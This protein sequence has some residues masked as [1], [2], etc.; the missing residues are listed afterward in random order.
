MLK[1]T[2]TKNKVKK[3]GKGFEKYLWLNKFETEASLLVHSKPF[4]GLLVSLQLQF[5][6]LILGNSLQFKRIFK[7]AVVCSAL[8]WYA[9]SLN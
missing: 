4:A 7:L 5:A 2:H 8:L 1:N 6:W 3:L 9:V